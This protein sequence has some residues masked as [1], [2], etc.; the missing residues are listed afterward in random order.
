MKSFE[1]LAK[2]FSLQ[3]TLYLKASKHER[4]WH[5]KRLYYIVSFLSEISEKCRVTTFVDVGCAEGFYVRYVASACNETFCI[6]ADV[7]LTYLKKAKMSNKAVNVDYILCDIEHLPFVDR[8]I[9]VV[10]CSEVLE[11][12]YNY[13][14][15]LRELVR[16]GKE[17]LVLSF[18]GHSYVYKIISQIPLLKRLADRLVLD[19][20]HVSEV[21]I[22]DVKS[23]LKGRI[24]SLKTKIGGALPLALI[25]LIPSVRLVDAIDNVLCRVLERF[26][27]VDYAT[28]HVVEVR[29]QFDF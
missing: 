17:Y 22:S 16:V 15:P 7:V 1:A 23:V 10:L 4:W 26:G 25:K 28:I 11:H 13:L 20:G 12:L 29:T 21:K 3:E 2:Q 24:K 6:G 14:D 27:A 5:R 19:V 8:S 9:D 18:P